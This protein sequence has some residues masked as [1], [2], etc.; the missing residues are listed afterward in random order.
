MCEEIGTLSIG[1]Y[2]GLLYS[3]RLWDVPR[4]CDAL[5]E[6]VPA[7]HEGLY[8]RMLFNFK[9]HDGSVR[10][11]AASPR[12]VASGGGDGTIAVFDLRAMRNVGS[13]VH[14]EDCVESLQFFG[15]QY[16]VSGGADRRLCLWRASDWAM[17]KE[18]N[19]HV[20]GITSHAVSA[21]GKFMLSAGKDG[22]LRMWDLM[23]GHNAKT[24][25]VGVIP[26]FVGLTGDSRR[27]LLGYERSVVVVDG[28]SEET[29][30]EFAHE[31]A[32]SCHCVAGSELWVGCVDG[33]VCAWSLETGA[34]LGEYVIAQDRIKFVHRE[35]RIIIILTSAG[36]CRV[37]LVSEGYD[38]DTVLAWSVNM[39]ITCGAFHK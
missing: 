26:A 11:L 6:G 32:V 31:R 35:G 13:L 14:H 19:G 5:P 18:L 1:T 36:D 7:G 39:R 22:A 29:V 2:D 30:F 17:V 21:T 8:A 33:H 16:L 15:D 28:V 38:I 23:H 10:S 27:F 3:Y 20:G 4:G 12:Y 25:R 37:G 9:P 24:R 34:S